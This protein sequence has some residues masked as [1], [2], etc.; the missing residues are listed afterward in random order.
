MWGIIEL[1]S[2]VNKL[3]LMCSVQSLVL[4]ILLYKF[5]NSCII[6]Q[7]KLGLKGILL[8]SLVQ[9]QL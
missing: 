4:Q 7:K 5:L 8:Q 6:N 1:N 2:C 9:N 3:V